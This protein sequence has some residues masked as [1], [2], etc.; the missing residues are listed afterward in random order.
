MFSYEE[1]MA[2]IK[3]LILYDINYALVLREL[4]YP[5]K[6]SLH[7]WYKEYL[8]NKDLHKNYFRKSKYNDELRQKAV[9]YY[10]HHGKCI[11]KTVRALGCPSRPI[12]DK[13]IKESIPESKKNCKAGGY[14]ISYSKDKKE[15]AVIDL[16]SRNVSAK[17]IAEKHNVSREVL[18]KWTGQLL[19]S[20]SCLNMHK[21]ENK[22]KNESNEEH[23]ITELLKEKQRLSKELENLQIETKKLRIEHDILEKASQII[24]KDK[25]INLNTLSNKEKATVIN[26][27]RDKYLLKELLGV[28]KMAKSSYCY[29]INVLIGPDKYE[30]LRE[31]IKQVFNDASKR[32]GYR[33]IHGVIKTSGKI[34]SEKIIRRIMKQEFLTVRTTRRRKYNSYIGEITPAVR[35][36]M[37]RNFKAEKPNT[38]WLTDITEFQIKAGKV[39]LSP[40]IDCFDGLVVSWTIGTSPDANLVNTMLDR[41]ILTLEKSECPIIHSDRGSHYRWPG[42]IER[43][44]QYN[45]TRSMS[46]KGCSPDNSAC[47]GFFGRLKNEMFY[48]HSWLEISTDQFIQEVDTYIRWYN[49]K[50]IKLSLGCLSP[51][52]YRKNLGLLA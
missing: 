4:G 14:L 19:G 34:I 39:Y 27:L 28:L 24:K 11:S 17:E 26:A 3:L 35:N 5:S 37:K 9:E 8:K 44:K 45:L 16:C 30:K 52:E 36:I 49:E 43:M 20:R 18:Y 42:W 29:Q 2:A 23:T 51:I 31:E 7:N 22:Y 21:K 32:Y 1:K 47:E 15:K 6:K 13:W 40:I 10:L 25:G 46:K 38:K 50:R 12:L 33:R 41:A 48:G